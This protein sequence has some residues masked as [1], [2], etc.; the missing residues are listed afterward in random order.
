MSQSSPPS[1]SSFRFI[2]IWH[3]KK[4]RHQATDEGSDNG[5]RRP[6]THAYDWFTLMLLVIF[7]RQ[8]PDSAINK[9]G[10]KLSVLSLNLQ[11]L[12]TFGGATEHTNNLPIWSVSPYQGEAVR[13]SIPT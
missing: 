10:R 13:S 2:L 7:C 1:S 8:F 12:E 9:K 6:D 4:R 3:E 11:A 5:R